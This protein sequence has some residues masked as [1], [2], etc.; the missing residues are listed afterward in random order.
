[1]LIAFTYAGPNDAQALLD[2]LWALS[3]SPFY[4]CAVS[5]ILISNALDLACNLMCNLK[6]TL[7]ESSFPYKVKMP[8][9]TVF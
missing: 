2:S 8:P 5:I 7:E 9:I 4:Y 3:A 6:E 1:M